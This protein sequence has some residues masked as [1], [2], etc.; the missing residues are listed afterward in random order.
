LFFFKLYCSCN[1]QTP[2]AN[3]FPE[4]SFTKT[5]PD[6]PVPPGELTLYNPPPPPPPVFVIPLPPGLVPPAP[7][8]PTPPA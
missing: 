7:P 2:D 8:P 1:D 6:P 4:L 5:I 3:I